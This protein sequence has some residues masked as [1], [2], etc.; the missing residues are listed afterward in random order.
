MYPPPSAPAY[1][2]GVPWPGNVPPG[3]KRRVSLAVFS[4]CGEVRSYRYIYI[5][6]YVYVYMYMYV[7]CI[8]ICIFVLCSLEETMYIIYDYYNNVQL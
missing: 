5:C 1:S 4:L 7:F 6:I 8:C 3:S 2:L